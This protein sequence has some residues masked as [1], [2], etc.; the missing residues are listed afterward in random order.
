MRALS[1]PARI[2]KLYRG[3]GPPGSVQANTLEA[4]AERCRIPRDDQHFVSAADRDPRIGPAEQR[5]RDLV[6]GGQ[7]VARTHMSNDW[8]LAVGRRPGDGIIRAGKLYV[9]TVSKGHNDTI[10]RADHIEPP[11]AAS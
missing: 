10:I 9:R 8:F 4:T 2:E 6:P 7:G 11:T 5:S 3:I 1:S